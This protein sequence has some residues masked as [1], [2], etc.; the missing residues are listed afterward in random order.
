MGYQMGAYKH[1]GTP[2]SDPGYHVL[3]VSADGNEQA[4]YCSQQQQE[5]SDEQLPQD[6]DSDHM[7]LLQ[8]QASSKTTGGRLE[9]AGKHGSG[10][11]FDQLDRVLGSNGG[12]RRPAT[13]VSLKQTLFDFTP[14]DP[15]HA[16]VHYL[17][18]ADQ[19]DFR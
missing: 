18:A 17:R 4:V 16:E 12:R 2:R 5:R 6:H 15:V 7:L 11:A 8:H 19:G 10:G 3:Q 14:V 1:P 9:E 13:A